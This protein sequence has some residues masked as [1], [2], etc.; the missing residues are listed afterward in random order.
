MP[1]LQG[2]RN[3]MI[4]QAPGCRKQ[5]VKTVTELARHSSENTLSPLGQPRLAKASSGW[6]ILE[7]VKMIYSIPAP[8]KNTTA[9][10]DTRT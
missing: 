4:N 8:A 7:P 10:P 3:E 5:R 2:T 6:T 1:A 9:L